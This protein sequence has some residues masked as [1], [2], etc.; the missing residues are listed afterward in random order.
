M[1]RAAA[2]GTVFALVAGASAG[3]ASATPP[4]KNGLIAFTQYAK[5]ERGGEPSAGAIFTIDASARATRRVTRPPAGASDVQP[6]WSPDG[7]R[8][9]FERRFEDKPYEVWSVRPDGSD[10]RQIDPGCPPGIPEDEICEEVSPAWSPDGERIAFGN[11]FGKLK[12]IGGVEWIEVGAVSVMDAD[13][14]NRRQLTQPRR[15]T[16]T[17]G[18]GRSRDRALPG[19]TAPPARP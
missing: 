9:V 16:T 10:L 15:P 7:S 5:A 18:R 8:I 17:S 13:G 14:S 2:A 1:L 3:S 6:D 11:P 12:Y 19:A 4:G